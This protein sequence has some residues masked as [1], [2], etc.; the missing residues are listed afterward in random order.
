MCSVPKY[1]LF[2][3]LLLV[4]TTYKH[5][6]KN[7]SI[8]Y[9]G[10]HLIRLLFEF[11]VRVIGSGFLLFL[12]IDCRD[13]DRLLITTYGVTNQQTKVIHKSQQI[14]FQFV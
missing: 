13:Y 10:L 11:S 2:T 6:L 4:Y 7:I 1:K 8:D 9:I 5:C 12:T 14:T 3:L